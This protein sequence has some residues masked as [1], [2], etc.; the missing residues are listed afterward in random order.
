M[1]K[2]VGG[3]QDGRGHENGLTI[4]FWNEHLPWKHCRAHPETCQRVLARLQQICNT[5]DSDG[6]L[7]SSGLGSRYGSPCWLA[8]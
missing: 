4:L 2:Q 6:L 5:G 3:S 7:G 1:V 8:L